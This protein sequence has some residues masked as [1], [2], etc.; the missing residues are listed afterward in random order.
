[1]IET[2]KKQWFVVLVAV[3]C[4]SF[5]VFCVYDTNKGKLPGKKVDGKE[6]IATMSDYTLT[7]DDLYPT[8]YKNYGGTQNLYLRFQNQVIDQSMKTTDEL[9]E[10]AK[11]IASNM[12]AQAESYA[13]MYGT[14][15]DAMIQQQLTYYG[16]DSDDMNGYSLM[17]AKNEK[18]RNDY[19]DAR[20][21]EL[22]TPVY[23]STKPRIVS[24]ILINVK[25]INNPTEEEQKKIDAVEKALKDGKDFAE[26][27]KEYSD[28]TGSKENGG[29]L[30]YSDSNTN[31]VTSF[32]EKM[33]S[34]KAGE[35][36][37]WVKE[38]NTSYSGWHKIMVTTTDKQE[39]E[40][41][42]DVR[43]GIYSAIVKANSDLA[44]KYVWEAAQKLD[45]T[46]ANDD[47]KKEIMDY[48]G[49]EE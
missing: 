17:A 37:D 44:F 11:T 36:S 19:I 40:D 18:L 12:Q 39:L 48:M 43:D 26:V 35:V 1:M 2:L 42:K 7:A 21:D 15:A 10:N 23:E 28:D 22:Y 46:Y 45:I 31:Y 13:S 8:L 47:V 38:S 30:G 41:N 32:K 3:I 27:A 4:V 33:L 9:K 6:V 16:F 20:L 24:H 25:D 34:M 5:V 29:Y 14:T 49:I